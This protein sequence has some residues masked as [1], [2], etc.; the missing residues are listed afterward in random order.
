M[1]TS[2]RSGNIL[3]MEL[4]RWLKEN[5]IPQARFARLVG[6]A[7]ATVCRWVKGRRIPVDREILRQIMLA[8]S[9][10]VRPGDFY[11]FCRKIDP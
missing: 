1:S 9:G 6:V 8:T 10:A 5:E 11:E 3:A 7:P 4:S 2:F